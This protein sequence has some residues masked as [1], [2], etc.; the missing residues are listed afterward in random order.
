M[1]GCAARKQY[2]RESAKVEK[3][4]A[5]N[6]VGTKVVVI[7]DDESRQETM[8]RSEAWV[9]CDHT[10]VVQLDGMA[11]CYLLDRVKTQEKHNG[12]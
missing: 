11:G 6:P 5:D 12:K 7:M 10:A 3:F 1:R 2:G 9:L 8:T 4:N